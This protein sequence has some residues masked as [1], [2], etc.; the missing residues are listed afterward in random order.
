MQQCQPGLMLTYIDSCEE[1]SAVEIDIT[2]LQ[3][4]KSFFSLLTII[5]HKHGFDLQALKQAR[6]DL[7]GNITH[8][9]THCVSTAVLSEWISHTWQKN[10]NDGRQRV[11]SMEQ[12]GAMK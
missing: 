6:P 3:Y 7:K 1:T 9:S 5:E 8:T 11:K 4:V 2:T 12:N 10:Q